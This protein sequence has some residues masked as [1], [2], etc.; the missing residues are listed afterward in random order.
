MYLSLQFSVGISD[1]EDKII[2]AL[3]LRKLSKDLDLDELERQ[4]IECRLS[5]GCLD[6]LGM[7]HKRNLYNISG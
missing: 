2:T 1:E 6:V 7:K 5:V 4:D 3:L